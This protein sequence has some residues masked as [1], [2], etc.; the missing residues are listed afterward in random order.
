LALPALAAG[1][2]TTVVTIDAPME[3]EGLMHNALASMIEKYSD[4]RDDVHTALLSDDH[5]AAQEAAYRAG[6]ADA[7]K[8]LEDEVANA[9]RQLELAQAK[10]KKAPKVTVKG[11]EYKGDPKLVKYWKGRLSE[12]KRMLF[13]HKLLKNAKAH[14]FIS[15]KKKNLI[16]SL[17]HRK[18]E[19][20]IAKTR[21]TVKFEVREARVRKLAWMHFQIAKTMQSAQKTYKKIFGKSVGLK[22]LA[23]QFPGA[24]VDWKGLAGT[25][26]GAEKKLLTKLRKDANKKLGIKAGG[27]VY[28]L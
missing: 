27:G 15:P 4:A 2:E 22:K 8:V 14:T 23:S 11:V 28:G 6:K 3:S 19:S 24:S 13:C 21:K 7:H 20:M 1:K 12:A 25:L 17:V 5:E 18:L 26:M 16:W 9:Q 10:P